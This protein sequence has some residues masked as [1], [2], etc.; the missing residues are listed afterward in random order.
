MQLKYR[1]IFKKISLGILGFI[2]A[3]IIIL[4]MSR[5]GAGILPDSAA[6]ISVA[7]SLIEGSGFITFDGNY[8]VLQPPLYP[9]LLASIKEVLKIDPIVSAGYLNAL[10]FGSIIYLSGLFLLKHLKSFTLVLL[11]TLSV[12]ISYALV[13]ASLMELSETLFIFLVLLFLYFLEKYR[14]KRDLVSFFLFSVSASLACLTRYTGVIIILTGIICM[15]LWGKNNIKEKFR[16][17]LSYTLITVLPV[18]IWIIRNYFLSGTFVGHRAA[19]TYTLFENF[20][21]FYG[22]V[23]PWYLPLNTSAIYFILIFLII[24]IWLFFK[25]EP[26]K[27]LNRERIKLIGPSLLFVLLYSG[28]IVISSTITAYDQISDR[29]LSPIYIPVIFILFFISDK[30]HSRLT[31]S[32]YPK[33][34]TVF[35]F[36]SIVLM[37][38]YPVKNTIRVIEEF[39]E[40]SGWG[41]SCDSWRKNETVEYLKQHELLWKNYTL[42]S[43]EPEA[44]YILTNLKTRRSPAKTFYNS[45]Q[46]FKNISHQMDIWLNEKKVCLIWFDNNNRSFLFTIDELQKTKNIT[47]VAHLKDG[48]IYTCTRK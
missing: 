16:H 38:S 36:I 10:L 47:E 14:T 37:M 29:L 21:F 30:I 20:S 41:Y 9:M 46:L 2:G 22:T 18:S 15:F 7:R 3:S 32:F 39:V 1:N 40:L 24:P 28:I 42:Y 17:S 25:L 27:S 31:K 8:Y 35:F 34:V 44:V 11:G 4:L 13:Q 45:Q 23:L 43:N 12:L 33:F 19:S 26:L 5:H 6:Y 48:E